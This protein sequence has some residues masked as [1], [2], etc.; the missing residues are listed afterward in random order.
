MAAFEAAIMG[1]TYP[2]RRGRIAKSDDFRVGTLIHPSTGQSWAVMWT[3]VVCS[4]CGDEIRVGDRV[5]ERTMGPH[6]VH[7]ACANEGGAR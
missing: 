6:L 4:E 2:A 3:S 7:T 5:V 1:K